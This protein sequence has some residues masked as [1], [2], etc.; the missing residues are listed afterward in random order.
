[1]VTN[2]E[3]TPQ[4]ASDA[5]RSG[6]AVLIDVRET[7]EWNQQRIAGAVEFLRAH[8]R[9]RAVNVLGGIE[10]WEQAGLPVAP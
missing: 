5:V 4:Q 6:E 2:G 3:A 10:G 7:W 9:P 1:M 8:G